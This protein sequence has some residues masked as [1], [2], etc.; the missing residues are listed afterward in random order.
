MEHEDVIRYFDQRLDEFGPTVRAVDWGSP[1]SQRARFAALAAVGVLDGCRV[2]DVGCGL[3]DLCGFL[4]S[5]SPGVEYEGCDLNPRMI[6]AAAARYPGHRFVVADLLT[7]PLAM[8]GPY[9]YVVA[10]G[11]FYLRDEAFLHAMVRRMLDFGR[12]GI[13]FNSLSAWADRRD[14]GEY[15]ADPVRV[16]TFCRSLTRRVAL[17]HDYLPNDFTVYAYRES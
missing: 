9:D 1:D 3:G 5:R 11:L 2:L 4:E 10:S 13:A 14:P 15:Y 12:R 8:P 6:A 16:L 7:E 17:R